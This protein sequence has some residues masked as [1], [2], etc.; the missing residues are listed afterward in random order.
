MGRPR[1][2]SAPVTD[3]SLMTAVEFEQIADELYGLRPGEFTAARDEHVTRAKA[4]GNK[5]LARDLGKLRRPTLSAWLVNALWRDSR[6][7]VEE[8]LALSDEFGAAMVAGDGKQLQALTASRRELEGRLAQRAASLAAEAGVSAGSDLLREVQETFGAALVSPD[9]AGEVRAGRLVRPLS[10]SG[11]GPGFA[12][13]AQVGAAKAGRKE[14][15]R[16]TSGKTTQRDRKGTEAVRAEDDARR[17]GAERDL[18]RAQDEMSTA[19]LELAERT[20]VAERAAEELGNLSDRLADLREQVRELDRQVLAAKQVAARE[21]R[22]REQAEKV[23]DRAR[24]AVR[25]A[26]QVLR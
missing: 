20:R 2:G 4:D 26:E 24:A 5:G 11:F 17:A 14:A 13:V 6:D 1:G 3:L 19:E 18:A 22:R 7:E 9:A 23:Y 25:S 10:Y 12:A 15:A 16:R 21:Q 8:L